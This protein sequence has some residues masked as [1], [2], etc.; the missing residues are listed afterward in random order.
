MTIPALLDVL[1]NPKAQ[2]KKR[3]DAA[4]ALAHARNTDAIGTL[5]CLLEE[6]SDF[7]LR[8]GVAEAL[9]KMGDSAAVDTLI[10]SLQTEEHQKVRRTVAQSLGKIGDKRAV[11]HLIHALKEDHHYMVRLY[12]AEAL[13]ILDDDSAIAPL[14]DALEDRN[15]MVTFYARDALARLGQ[16]YSEV[17]ARLIPI[18]KSR[19]RSTM[20]AILIIGVLEKIN[21][22][23]VIDTLIMVLNEGTRRVPPRDNFQDNNRRLLYESKRLQD[24]HVREVAALA[25]G[26]FGDKRAIAALKER[27]ND[28]KEHPSLYPHVVQAL[29]QLGEDITLMNQFI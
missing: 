13:G 21:Q 29:G 6:D 4:L 25:L 27:F 16:K 8:M 22:P 14:V 18:L 11:P 3:R 5:M 17:T 7:K 23:V 19:T 10:L 28:P 12:A 15:Y 24:T 2:S 9:G 20:D 26:K 1:S